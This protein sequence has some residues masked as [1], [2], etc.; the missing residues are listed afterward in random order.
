MV[1]LNDTSRIWG[2][3]PVPKG[4]NETTE[5]FGDPKKTWMVNFRVSSLDA[6]VA[7][8][9]AAGIS[10]DV[11]QQPYPNGRFARLCDPEGNPI[12]LWEPAGRYAPR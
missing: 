3:S 9:R 1:L 7:Q 11:D 12:G 6:M 4:Y 2:I 8:L 5:H 10:V